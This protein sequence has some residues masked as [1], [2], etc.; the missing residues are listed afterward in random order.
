MNP[1]MEI[2]AGQAAHNF[3]VVRAAAAA[4]GVRLGLVTKVVAGYRPLVERL[5]TAGADS[6]GEAHLATLA[7]YADLA[8]EKWMIRSP[9]PSQVDEV[10]RFADVSLVSEVATAR[11]LGTAALK[12]G[13]HHKVVVMVESGD[14]REGV[15]PQEAVRTCEQID[16]ISGVELIGI[17]T[18]FGCLSDV[19]PSPVAMQEFAQLAGQVEERLGR[20]LAVVSGG[21]S[22]A[23]KM[24]VDGSLPPGINHLRIGESILTGRIVNYGIPLSD[25]FQDTI[26]LTA[27]LI[28]IKDKP[29]QPT[30]P[31]APGEP[32][33]ATDS[34]YPDRGIRRRGLVAIGKQ[35]TDIHGLTPL[36][37][38]VTIAGA[39]SDVLVVDLTDS[40]TPYGLGDHISFRLDYAAILHA[41]VSPFVDKRLQ[42]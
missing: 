17:G 25:C 27:E 29:S 41:M 30:G 22:N 38:A 16:A 28:E 7:A 26:T 20:P 32:P 21:S 39:S 1:W 11:A 42:E 15:L 2:R 33:V 8:V 6:I 12:Q 14:R 40:P 24:L 23:L 37:P 36:D 13:R 19:V 9:A 5:V 3:A 31:R 18:E 10:V 34:S 35:D 4:R